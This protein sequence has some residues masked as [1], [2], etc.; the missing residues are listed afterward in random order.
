MN[1]THLVIRGLVWLPPCSTF[2]F[3]L[4]APTPTLTHTP[5]LKGYQK[6][7]PDSVGVATFRPHSIIKQGKLWKKKS[8]ECNPSHEPLSSP[9][10]NLMLPQLSHTAATDRTLRCSL[11]CLP[12]DVVCGTKC[13]QTREACPQRLR[14]PAFL[15][16]RTSQSLSSAGS[17]NFQG[18]LCPNLS[19]LRTISFLILP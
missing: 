11:L 10:V 14:P 15:I 12:Y 4:P 5:W 3:S 18:E 19:D 7:Q 9:S 13:A 8:C 17:P 1:H 16:H 2:P 6:G